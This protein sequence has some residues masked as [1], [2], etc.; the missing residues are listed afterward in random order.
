MREPI[1]DKLRWMG[2]RPLT[3]AEASAGGYVRDP[4][5]RRLVRVDAATM[6]MAIVA[7]VADVAGVRRILDGLATGTWTYDLNIERN[8]D[9]LTVVNELRFVATTQGDAL[10][11]GL[12]ALGFRPRGG[13]WIDHDRACP[14]PDLGPEHA[15]EIFPG[16]GHV[17][18]PDATSEFGP[19]ER[20]RGYYSMVVPAG[21]V[22]A[23]ATRGY[24]FVHGGYPVRTITH[25]RVVAPIDPGSS[26]DSIRSMV[27]EA[28]AAAYD[29]A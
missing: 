21:A 28:V 14:V 10:R 4:S 3:A 24:R 23:P 27:E 22:S 25:R 11:N 2:F 1:D 19:S 6:S 15:G 17:L 20:R 29:D 8:A 18:A 9:A 5:E 12:P 26:V 16:V 13:V 7:P